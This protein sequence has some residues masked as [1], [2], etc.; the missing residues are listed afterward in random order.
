MTWRVPSEANKQWCPHCRIHEVQIIEVECC[1]PVGSMNPMVR[2]EAVVIPVNR[3]FDSGG[4]GEINLQDDGQGYNNI[5]CVA[6]LC[7][8]W[9]ISLEVVAEGEEQPGRCGLAGWSIH[10]QRRS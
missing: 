7:S 6:D 4:L 2:Q 3:L 1:H 10:H 5:A 9:E 8:Q